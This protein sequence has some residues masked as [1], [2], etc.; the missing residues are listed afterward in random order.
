VNYSGSKFTD[1]T[2]RPGMEQPV[3][4]WVPSIAPCG[5][6]FIT[7]NRFPEWKGRLLVGSLKFNYVELLTLKGEKV[8]KRE[9]IAED[10][11]RVRNVKMGPDG[12]IYI[13]VESDGIYKLSPDK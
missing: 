5:M 9:K 1:E 4:Y 11:G 10:I 2:E 13:A 12:Y 7:G 3:Y 8:V 6:A